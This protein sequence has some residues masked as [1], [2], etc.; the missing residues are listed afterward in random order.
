MGE[1]RYG[2]WMPVN[3]REQKERQL[4]WSKRIAVWLFLAINAVSLVLA[5]AAHLPRMMGVLLL[6]LSFVPYLLH[7][8]VVSPRLK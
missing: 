4:E 5:Y 3:D 1:Q 2:W 8:H 6:A 7:L